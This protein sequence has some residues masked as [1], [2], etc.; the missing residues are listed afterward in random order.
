M[1]PLANRETLEIGNVDPIATREELVEDI[2]TKLNIREERWIETKSLRMTQWETQQAVVV[3]PASTVT[4]DRPTIKVKTRL[5]IASARILPNVLKWYRCHM[6]GHNVTR[7]TVVS[8]GKELCRRCGDRGH[9][10]NQCTKEPRCDICGRR[11]GIS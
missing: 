9:T 5:T 10:I 1:Y 6:L 11:T 3:L 7:C 2:S 8:T 4:R